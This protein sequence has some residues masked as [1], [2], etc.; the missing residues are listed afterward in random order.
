MNPEAKENL[1]AN[2][3]GDEERV[4]N[5]FRKLP[6]RLEVHVGDT[7]ALKFDRDKNRLDLIP[8]EAIEKIG[9]V[10][11]YGAQKYSAENWRKGFLDLGRLLAATL[12]HINAYQQGESIDPESGLPHLAHA[13]TDLMMLL[14][15]SLPEKGK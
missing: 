4:N 7:Q 12:R 2:V 10:F 13:A 3:A 14:T 11:T 1:V 6:E 5:G 9:N 8:A 15:L